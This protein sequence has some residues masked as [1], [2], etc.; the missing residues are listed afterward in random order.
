V[1]C[2]PESKFV[3]FTTIKK[4]CCCWFFFIFAYKNIF[5][6][7]PIT[8]SYDKKSPSWH[9]KCDTYF[10]E[11]EKLGTLYFFCHLA[12]SIK[13]CLYFGK[14]FAK[15]HQDQRM[16]SWKCSRVFNFTRNFNFKCSIFYKY[17]YSNT[18]SG[19]KTIKTLNIQFSWHWMNR[20]FFHLFSFGSSLS[21]TKNALCQTKLHVVGLNCILSE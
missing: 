6:T 2:C 21:R 14:N 16:L 15:F 20:I 11:N 7:H 8:Y 12:V 9:I 18:F 5:P 19:P 4:S 1:I 13:N 17:F 3:T 10:L